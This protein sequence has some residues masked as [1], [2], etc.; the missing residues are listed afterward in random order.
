MTSPSC[1]VG[2]EC[3]APT[4]PPAHAHTRCGRIRLPTLAYPATPLRHRLDRA[5]RGSDRSNQSSFDEHAQC[6]DTAV[7]ALPYDFDRWRHLWWLQPPGGRTSR[8]RSCVW[9]APGASHVCATRLHLG[10]IDSQTIPYRTQ[11]APVYA[12]AS[13][14]P[15]ELGVDGDTQGCGEC[16]G[17]GSARRPRLAHDGKPL[18]SSPPTTEFESAG[19]RPSP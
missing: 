2:L 11:A 4:S 10:T 14:C 8:T 1:T 19:C 13:Q 5:V 9:G 17:G 7:A 15:T 16:D 6:T 3:L 12:E 18:R